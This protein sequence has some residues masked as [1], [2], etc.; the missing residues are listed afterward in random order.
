MN[1]E[2]Y[3]VVLSC[4][5]LSCL[6]HASEPLAA[7]SESEPNAT[8]NDLQR[9]EYARAELNQRE[10]MRLLAPIKSRVDLDVHLSKAGE[11]DSPLLRLSSA[12]RQG[13]IDSLT[14]NDRGLTGFRYSDLE[15]ELSPSEIYAILSLF[16]AQHLARQMTGARPA[17]TADTL[18]L[19]QT[20]RSSFSKDP[21]D[22]AGYWC[23]SPH[24]CARKSNYI[25]MSGC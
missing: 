18:I 5:V 20:V 15:A 11:I 1:K 3:L 14:F 13:F 9:Q 2:I 19:G 6:A 25:C 10:L 22:H 17:S 16:G 4:L 12:G 7:Q 23:S 8:L 24:T 21:G